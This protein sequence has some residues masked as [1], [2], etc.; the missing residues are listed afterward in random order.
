[1]ASHTDIRSGTRLLNVS[2]NS[3]RPLQVKW[4]AFLLVQ[5]P[6]SHLSLKSCC[7]GGAREVGSANDSILP[8][9]GGVR[10]RLRERLRLLLR[11]D[12]RLLYELLRRRDPDSGGV[13]ERRCRSLIS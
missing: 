6:N 13:R 10:E 2:S 8:R 9:F 12:D 11:D 1:M 7:P 4:Y 3:S 5:Y